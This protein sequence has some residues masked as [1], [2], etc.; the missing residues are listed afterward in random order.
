MAKQDGPK[1][2]LD[3]ILVGGIGGCMLIFIIPFIFVMALINAYVLTCL[4]DWFIVTTFNVQSLTL[5]Q[6]YG[7]S[8][9]ISY[10]QHGYHQGNVKDR[11]VLPKKDGD[12]ED[13]EVIYE[14][15]SQFD[16]STG[17]KAFELFGRIIL[18]PALVLGVGKLVY[19]YWIVP[20]M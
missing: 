7:I 5:A 12:D 18:I 20:G 16:L 15:K 17:W 4:W 9:F 2:I 13:C 14:L 1:T 19:I 10:L 3:W 6:A 8:L 11:I